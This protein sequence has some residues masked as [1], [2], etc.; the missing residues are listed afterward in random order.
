MVAKTLDKITDARSVLYLAW[1][2]LIEEE[3]KDF[4]H[5]HDS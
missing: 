2:E 5:L 1:W 3:S 4:T